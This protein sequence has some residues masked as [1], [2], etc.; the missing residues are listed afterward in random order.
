M[1]KV[2]DVPP[3]VKEVLTG[4]R[5]YG[6][7]YLWQAVKPETRWNDPENELIFCTGP[8]SGITFIDGNKGEV[9]IETFPYQD[10]N[11]YLLVEKLTEH[12]AEDEQDKANISIVSAGQGAQNSL[13]GI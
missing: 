11:S 6:L 1:V 12:F 2:K 7:W 10:I 4:G 13:L 5:G 8:L 3:K 9:K